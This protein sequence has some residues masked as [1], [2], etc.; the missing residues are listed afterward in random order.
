MTNYKNL[1]EQYGRAVL[2]IDGNA[3]FALLGG[4]LQEGEAEFVEVKQIGNEPLSAAECRA[5]K[6]RALPKGPTHD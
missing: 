3:G 4:D 2:G 6:L 5:A 1:Q